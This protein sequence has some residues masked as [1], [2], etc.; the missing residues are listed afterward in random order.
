MLDEH[1]HHHHEDGE[2]SVG[3]WH[4]PVGCDQ[5]LGV[6]EQ[7]FFSLLNDAIKQIKKWFK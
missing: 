5:Q 2:L 1:W 6:G 7:H 4:V 3:G